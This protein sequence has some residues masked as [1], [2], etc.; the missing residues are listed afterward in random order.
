MLQHLGRAVAKASVATRTRG[1]HGT[2]ARAFLFRAPTDVPAIAT[3]NGAVESRRYVVRND[4]LGFSMQ[5]EVLRKDTPVRLEFRNHVYAVLVT[6]GSGSLQLFDSHGNAISRHHHEL[7]EGSC[8]A[9]S[10]SEQIEIT[11]KT[12]ELHVVSVMNPPLAGDEQ[13]NPDTGVFP[14][15]DHDG[16]ERESFDHSQIRRLCE[17]P[18]S[19]KGGSSPMKDDPLF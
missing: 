16:I 7:T 14:V 8:F 17:P 15:I 2:S 11:A 1:L 9:L 18:E 6:K 5:H 3:E 19:L 4:G 10:A 12:D 13:R